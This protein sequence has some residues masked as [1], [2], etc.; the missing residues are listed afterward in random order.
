MNSVFL[1]HSESITIYLDY[2]WSGAVGE[3]EM[4]GQ[5]PPSIA[6]A[7]KGEEIGGFVVAVLLKCD[8]K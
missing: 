4:G 1:T 3:V 6:Y 5:L 2:S 8:Y 7:L